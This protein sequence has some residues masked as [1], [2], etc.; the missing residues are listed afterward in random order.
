M[1]RGIQYKTVSGHYSPFQRDILF[2]SVYDSSLPAP[3]A[4]AGGKTLTASCT[5]A[6]ACFDS[7][8]GRPEET[9]L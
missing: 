1:Q 4:A 2:I 8:G 3:T 6:P 7:L 5:A 9:W